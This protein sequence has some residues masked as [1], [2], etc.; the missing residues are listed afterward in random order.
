MLRVSFGKTL[1][2][3]EGFWN[4]IE[5]TS[6]LLSE[7]QTQQIGRRL[8]KRLGEQ[9]TPPRRKRS[10]PRVVRQPVRR[11]PRL[12]KNISHQ[13]DFKYEVVPV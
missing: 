3:I 10:C 13:A 5:L 7:A 2:W 8:M 1:R 11:W 4:F 9:L 6:G 12:Q